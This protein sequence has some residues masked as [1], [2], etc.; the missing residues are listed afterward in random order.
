M[1][2]QAKTNAKRTGIPNATNSPHRRSCPPHLKTDDRFKEL[3]NLLPETVFETDES[4]ILTFV[5]RNAFSAFGYTEEDF[6]RGLNGLDMIAPED[7]ER[8]AENM[9]ARLN[10]EED[11]ASEYTALRKDGSTFPIL[12]HSSPILR[13]GRS[14]GLRGIIFDITERKQAEDALR[15]AGEELEANVL[16]RTTEFEEANTV[17]RAEIKEREKAENALRESEERLKRYLESSPDIICVVDLKGILLYVN[18]A[19]E[20]LT[21]YKRSELV[22]KSFQDLPLLS[23][24]HRSKPT[25]W[26][27]EGGTQK[28]TRRDEFEVVRK[29][30]RRA[31][32]EISTFPMGQGWNAEI[33]AIG[34]DVTERRHAQ[35]EK[36]VMEQ[37]VQLSGR[38][39]A[40]GQLA[41]GVAHELN[42]PLAAVQGFAQLLS[43]RQ[44]LDE[45][46]RS[47]VETILREAQRASRITANLLSFARKHEP[48]RES[49]CL[50]HTVE[51]SVELH[52]YRM[53]VNNV[54]VS[55]D[56]APDLPKTMGDF[57]QLQQVFVNIITNAEQAMTEAHGSGKLLIR[58]RRVGDAILIDFTD[59]GPGIPEEN[60]KRIFDPFF[61]TKEVGK[62][63]GLGLSICYGVVEK[64]DGRM[65]ATSEVGKG[66]TFSV[67]LPITTQEQSET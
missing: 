29:D 54:E 17:L 19:T 58:T 7:R 50:N 18:K 45:S 62:G 14:V 34:R 10:G 37:Q 41:A 6:A 15:K 42:N 3:A 48:E 28:P 56:L 24:E 11:G 39:A 64:H 55:M 31:F 21:G 38:L 47:D 51:Q 1:K 43:S 26:V 13:D 5:N 44:A 40:V 67:E 2:T 27:Y 66:T 16:Q 35:E 46:V 23:P 8:A 63:T 61:T 57:H 30:G 20:E 36:A 32:V 33:I 9:L 4:G 12:L 65:Y 49:I 60:M 22:G 53:R 52:A 59:D 25:Q